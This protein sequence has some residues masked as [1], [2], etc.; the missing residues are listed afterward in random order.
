MAKRSKMSLAQKAV[1]VATPGLPS[2]LKSVVTS[3]LGAPLTLIVI[4]ALAASGVV[5]LNWSGGRPQVTVDRQRVNDIRQ[6][7]EAVRGEAASRPAEQGT[8]SLPPVTSSARPSDRLR[9]ASFNIQVFGTAKAQKPPVMNVLAD[10]IRRFDVVAIQELRT[11]DPFAMDSLLQLVNQN[12]GTF[13]YVV[14]PRL[15]RTASKEQYVFLFDLAR[16]ELLP[17]TLLTVSDPQDLLHREPLIARFRVRASGSAQPFTFIL[18]N[19]HTD[20]DETDTELDALG[21]VFRAIQQNPWQEDD[22]ILLG[23]LNV[24]YRKMGNLGM[25]PDIAWTIQGQ[26][27]N[28]RGLESYD[29]I[30]FNRVATCEFTG[31]SGVLNLQE[32]YRLTTEQALEVSDHQPIWAEFNV[33]EGGAALVASRPLPTPANLVPQPAPPGG[34]S[35]PPAPAASP[36]RPGLR[37]LLNRTGTY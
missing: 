36:Q 33:T 29:N 12:G 35:P 26:P 1:S 14:G 20:P 23:D 30:V 6:K 18:V 27:T 17:D 7:V 4:V 15:G 24:D 34:P 3:R 37:N 16:V 9:I 25:L 10:V 11:P 22:V 8:P 31:T 13:Q 5:K 21:G 28:T 32:E 2:P 19:I